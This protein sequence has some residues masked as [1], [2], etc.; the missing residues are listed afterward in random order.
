MGDIG[1]GVAHHTL[2]RAKKYTKKYIKNKIKKYGPESSIEQYWL[3]SF[4]T[5]ILGAGM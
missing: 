3:R 4:C 1:K 5:L 2:A